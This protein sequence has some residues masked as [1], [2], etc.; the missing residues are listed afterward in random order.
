M[1]T[2]EFSVIMAVYNTEAFLEE[3]LESLAQQSYG[4]EK[5]Q[6]ILVDDG[7][8]DGSGKI[9]DAYAAKQPQNV[10]ALHKPNGGQ[11]SARNLGLQYAE[12]KWLNFLDS[13]DKLEPDVFEK[14]AAF[15]AE[16]GDETDVV[17]IPMRFFGNKKGNH[18]INFRFRKGTRIANLEEEWDCF[19]FSLAA[20]FVRADSARKYAFKKNRKQVISEDAREIAYIL[21][22]RQTIG[23]VTDCYYL[24]RKW[25]GSTIDNA[26]KKKAYY[27]KKCR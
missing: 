21:I 12:G 27:M 10:I 22:H 13:D 18:P 8:T 24:Y 20:A 16:H 7:S 3:A 19:Q 4:F 6:V 26:A 9:C 17:A 14:V 23:L 2:F 15:I 1:G 11:S 5:I 25:G